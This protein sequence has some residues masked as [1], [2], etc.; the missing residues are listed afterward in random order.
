MYIEIKNLDIQQI[1]DDFNISK[2]YIITSINE[3]NRG[4]MIMNEIPEHLKGKYFYHF[5]H[6]E[7]LESILKNGFLSTNRKNARRIGH[8]NIAN[9]TIQHRRSAMDV[10]CPPNGKVHDYVP[11]Y[12]TATNPMLLSL[13]NN[14]NIDQPLIIFFAIHID[15]ILENN[16]VFTDASANT[17]TPP[18]FYNTPSDLEKLDWAAIDKRG[19][20]SANDYERHKRMA[21]VLVYDEVPLDWIDSIIVWNKDIKKYVIEAFKEHSTHS[22]TVTCQPFNGRHFYFTKFA[23]GRGNETLVTGPY[24]L[25]NKFENAI[26]KIIDRRE[27]QTNFKFQNIEVAIAAI[28][29]DFCCISE[30]EGIYELKTSN[31]IH[32]D[33]VS[34]HTKKVVGN[35]VD[36]FYFTALSSG[37]QNIVKLSAYL[38]DIGKGP[39]SKW[40]DEIQPSY[41]DHPADAILMLERILTEDFE[42]LSEYEIRKICLLVIY[43]DLIGDI[44]ANNRSQKELVDLI[45]DK[46]ELDM[47]IAISLADVSAINFSWTI[48]LQSK[49]P[50]LIE[51]VHEALK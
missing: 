6:I 1:V 13:V 35:L 4:K 15:K 48:T 22:P 32:S 51:E 12:F 43:H 25:K 8:T 26:K 9:E 42:K 17:S 45:E 36:N 44:I 40:E 14:K 27:T 2:R 50:T 37:D 39:K 7:N 41:P 21:E 47:L 5:T 18:N 31:R 28:E 16:V 10:T 30:L 3:Y 34:N 19:W 20:G 11:F 24:F 38:H 29:K 46:N 23:L 33:N 49:L